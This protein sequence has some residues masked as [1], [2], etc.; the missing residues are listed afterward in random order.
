MTDPDRAFR[1]FPPELF[2]RRREAVLEELADGTMVLPAAPLRYRSRDTEHRYRPDSEL[3]YLTGVTEPGSVAVLRSWADEDRFVLFVRE[4]NAEAERWS[5]SRLGPDGAAER[6]GADAVHPL[7]ELEERM[8]DL[9]AGGRS[10]HFRLGGDGVPGLIG[11]TSAAAR[12]RTLVLRSLER[13]RRKG[14]RRGTGPRAVIDPGEILDELRLRKDEAELERIRRAAALTV[15]GFREGL[16]A[17]G[18]GVGEWEVEAALESS[19]RRAGAEG[20]AFPTIVG[21]GANAC[22]LHY[23]ENGRRMEEGDLVLV[24]GGAEV[25]LY[26]GDVTRTVPVSGAFGPEQRALYDIVEEARRTAVAAV[27]PGAT[28]AD[29]HQAC[30]RVLVEGMVEVG[31]LTGEV[32]A[33]L[34]EDAHEAYF[35]HRTS[36]WLGLDVHDPGDYARGGENRILEA[37][38]VLTVEPGLYVPATG[39]GDGREGEEAAEYLDPEAAARFA[40]IGIRIEDD[41]LVTA[42]GRENLTADLPTDP[43]A[44]SELAGRTR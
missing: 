42:D 24:D 31:L 2:A 1:G 12:C 18:A 40:G 23:V 20:P 25:D 37:G 35:P 41:V 14:P 11:G 5:G 3:F 4:R 36:H 17:V 38:M 43:D 44:V 32:E 21:S 8:P 19:L 6:F 7:G 29:V 33:L 27:E 26:H 22:I 10:V 30:L 13:A 15:E 28:V 39:P 16:G 9:L 34:E